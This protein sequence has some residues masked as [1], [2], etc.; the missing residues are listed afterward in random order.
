MLFHS[1]MNAFSH[2]DIQRNISI[3]T[4]CPQHVGCLALIHTYL[5]QAG[6]LNMKMP[7]SNLGK[8]VSFKHSWN[9]KEIASLFEAVFLSFTYVFKFLL[10]LFPVKIRSFLQCFQ[11]NC[12][13]KM[14][15]II[16]KPVPVLL[17]CQT[18]GRPLPRPWIQSHENESTVESFRSEKSTK[19]ISSNHQPITTMPTNHVPGCDIYPFLENLQGPT[20]SRF[21]DR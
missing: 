3:Y 6:M 1:E 18:S 17:S 8:V 10:N 5:Q 21:E 11:G 19:I 9:K 14:G 7:L 16:F 4:A 12:R 2:S 13:T 20:R 15:S